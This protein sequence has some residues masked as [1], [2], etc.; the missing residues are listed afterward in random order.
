MMLL[1]LLRPEACESVIVEFEITL[2]LIVLSLIVL[3][4][5]VEFLI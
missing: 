4:S 3:L 2:L 1:V 5:T